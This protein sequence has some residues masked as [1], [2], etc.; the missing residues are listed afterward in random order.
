VAFPGWLFYASVEFT[1]NNNIWKNISGLNEYITRC[2]SFLQMG[3]PD[4]DLV[5]YWPVYDLWYNPKGLDMPFKIH[6]T[7]LQ[8]SKFYSTTT[9]LQKNGFDF[10]HISDNFI[11]NARVEHGKIKVPGGEY[12]ALVI[13]ES[14]FMPLETL[15]KIKAMA[16]EGAKIVFIDSLPSD[17]PGLSS[18][19]ANREQFSK[20]KTSLHI[21]NASPDGSNFIANKGEVII[22]TL[23][24]GVFDKLDIRREDIVKQ[25]VGCN[26]RKYDQGNIYFFTNQQSKA[27]S[28]WVRLGVSAKSAAIYDPLTGRSG[29]ARLREGKDGTEVFLQLASDESLILKTWQNTETKAQLWTYYQPSAKA[30]VL[31]G[32]W[33]L[34]LVEGTPAI[35]QEFKLDTLTS[36]T[37]LNNADLSIFSGTGKYVLKFTLPEQIA[38]NWQLDL[39]KVCESARV[40]INGKDA[41]IWWSIPF[42]A[43]VGEY[44][45]KGE[46]TIEIEVTNLSANRIADMDRKGIEWRKFKEINFVDLNYKPFDTSSWKIMNSG[47]L[48]PVTLTPMKIVS[49]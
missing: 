6:D 2:Q 10:D 14:R 46:N 16:D 44:L 22:T 37:N 15:K 43:N 13:P 25:G 21:V 33:Q 35:K 11:L 45:K 38:D 39:G 8:P 5:V 30:L 19:A 34:T 32:P 48:G 29:I 20:L 40:K 17:V 12:K 23:F 3:Q 31:K 9:W 27:L 47:L 28:G 26:R 18:L 1:P 42:H 7:W 4:N 49:N 24:P 36:W 41:G